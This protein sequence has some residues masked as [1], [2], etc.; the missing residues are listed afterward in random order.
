MELALLIIASLLPGAEPPGDFAL[1]R[2]LVQKYC[3][4]CHSTKAKKG[5]LDLERFATVDDV[6][7]DVKPW[8]AVVEMLEAGEMPPKGK[9]QPSVEERKRI[10][11]WTR[12][13][14][15]AEAVARKGDPGRVPLRRLSHAEYDATIRDLAGVDL[16]PAREFPADGAG[17]EGF[18]NAAES[19]ADIS[20]ALLDKYLAAAKE[21][22]AHAV[23]LPNGFRF[24]PSKTRRDWTDECN[25]RLRAF[26]AEFTP[27]GRLPQRA[28]L[29]EAVRHRDELLAGKTTPEAVA[30]AA[31]L[32][33]KFFGIVWQA[34]NDKTPSFP[35]DQLRRRWRTATEKDVDALVAEVAAW[36]P[37]L[38]RSVPI[39]SY[40]DLQTVRQLPNDPP[41]VPAQTL[42]VSVKPAPGQND[43]VL[44]LSARELLGATGRVVWQ[45]P[46]FEAPGQPPL[47]LRD[48]PRFGPRFEVDYSA[49][50]A[51]TPKY[52]SAVLES[53]KSKAPAERI[54]KDQ[55]LDAELL[56]RWIS[57]LALAP[58]AEGPRR[59]V[60]ATALVP[61]AEKFTQ[62]PSVSGW[63]RRGSD[64]PSLVANSSDKVENIPGRVPPH[65][66]AVH[67]T[68]D[69]FV[70]VTWTS[71]IEGKVRVSASIVH[72]H[73]ACGN[74][75]AW[76]VEYRHGTRAF[77]LAQ[78]ALDL[79]KE[80]RLQP[81]T[82]SVAKG[83]V[84]MLAVDARDANHVCDLTDIDLKITEVAKPG[85]KWN[86]AADINGDA[87]AGN[88]HGVWSFVE[89][90]AKPAGY[91]TA[92]G[93]A[94]PPGSLLARWRDAALD[95]KRRPE[96]DKLAEQ[97]RSLLVG[98]RPAKEKSPDRVLYDGLVTLDGPLL[99]G[100]DL[101]RFHGVHS[102]NRYGLPKDRYRDVD[103]F[104]DA[105]KDIEV[106]LPAALF[107][108]SEFVVDARLDPADADRAV[109]FRVTTAPPSAATW[110][111]KGPIVA[112]TPARE[113]LIK[114]FAEF[115]RLFPPNVCFPQIIPTDEVVCLKLFHR[116]DEPLTRLF[117]NDE[118]AKRLDRLWAEHRFVTQ[119]PITE[120]KNLPLFIGFVTQD[121]PKE[122]VVFYEKMR[123]P[124]RQRAEAFERELEAAAPAQLSQLADFASRAL[125]RPLREGER[126][127]FQKL[128]D[129]MRKKGVGHDEAFRTVLARVLVSPSFLFHVEHS[130]PGKEPRPVGDRELASRLSYFLWASVPDEEL[131]RLADARKLH[132]PAV[133]EQQARRMLQD[134]RLRSLAIEFG[135]QMIH[136]R[137]F[138]ELKEKNESLFPTFND[139]LRKAIYEESILF[140]QDL[141]QHDRPVT[142]LIDADD[143]YLNETL[144]RHYGIPGVVGPKWRRVEGVKKYGRGG[145]LGLASVQTKEA[146][147]SRT[148][149]VLRGNWVVETL[150]GEKLP[151]P[152]ANVPRLPEDERGNDGLTVRQLVAKHTSVPECAVCHVRIDPFGFALER[153]DPIGRWRDRD[154]GGLPIDTHVKLKDGTEFDGIDGLRHYL[155][156]KKKDVVVRL[157]C[158]KLL[159]YALGRATTLSDQSLID[160]MVAELNK[161]EGRVTAAVIAIIRSPQFRMIRGAD[162]E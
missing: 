58:D 102:P 105:G 32:S 147:A 119:W 107:H 54:A 69:R 65:Q 143:T 8:Q 108:G 91:F 113:R 88:P 148:S 43:V 13:F 120:H 149:P 15:D 73:P 76:F 39:G 51:D 122:L 1:V 29:L 118:Q 83:D 31:N 124:F 117:L 110:D 38:W 95:P 16:R 93:L 24:S 41:V 139:E 20:P 158:R 129:A 10:V 138:D 42:R 67:P 132:E 26:F 111:G 6:R 64:L 146:G 115:R 2:P 97:L 30:A 162:A 145:V 46:R 101:D 109:Q 134:L 47:L 3:L 85:R 37:P 9:S 100:L 155:M 112:S 90:P 28:Y 75:V 14:L 22:A 84:V 154:L 62:N 77:E 55:A 81:R 92:S 70:A 128:Y 130:P 60:A 45:R 137:G 11:A 94:I 156:T 49:A 57:L 25:A 36:Q 98:S 123:E 153:Y 126:A 104:T 99:A 53:A 151:R 125:R 106:R 68:P 72:A 19:L 152:P 131:R 87:A 74:G 161:N 7:K 35:L 61:L 63:R 78:G 89:G 121:Q 140:F 159:G 142:R 127:E 56:K 12:G 144:A 48:Y 59:E 50:F 79:G 71:P 33:P 23:L 116:E 160:E 44:H 135:T 18:T 27:D 114:G 141:F 133:L 82:L 34:L 21:I 40:R 157:F 150:L 4:G 52:L 80:A 66:V 96:A 136:V 103:V 17:G 5:D 86:L